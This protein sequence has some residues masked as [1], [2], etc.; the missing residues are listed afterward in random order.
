MNISRPATGVP[1]SATQA[2]TEAILT[3][4]VLPVLFALALPTIAVLFI[5]TF[6]GLTETYFVSSLGSH[7][8]AGV[9]VVFPLLMLMQM[10][11]NGG[12]GSGLAAAVARAIGAGRSQ[13]A[14][15]LVWH[16][17]W[18]AI[19]LGII[20]SAALIFGG[21][22]LYR[23]MGVSG[24][25]L[26]AALAY[27]NIIFLASPLIWL[28]AMLSAAMR[29]AGDT[30]TP[31]RIT[32][33]GAL[34]LLPISPLLIFG[35]GPV[36]AFGVE[37]AGMAI[38]LYYLAAAILLVKRMLRPD[39]ALELVPAPLNAT[40]F[41]EIAGVGMLASVGTVQINLTVAVVTA[42]VGT[43]G[44]A[45]VAGYGIASRLEYIQVP[46]LFGLG[47]AIMTM[48]GVNI[49]AGQ[50]KRAQRIAWI[51]A[52]VAFIFTSLIGLLAAIAPR[53]WLTLFSQD[54]EIL[55]VGSSYMHHVAPFYGCIGAAM[56]L[57]FA[58]I[59]MKRVL[60]PVLAG[61][62]RM[63]VAAF[64]G[65]IAVGY[66]G[67]DIN[68]LFQIYALSAVLYFA[69]TVISIWRGNYVEELHGKDGSKTFAKNRKCSE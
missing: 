5:Q 63:I 68:T 46:L 50:I 36:P 12:F 47:T 54:P 49:G 28:V 41:L 22:R 67:S 55:A 62:V 43:F 40:S 37:G 29:G 18:V 26:E 34:L 69:I 9:S 66:F 59:A 30:A 24:P 21:P 64:I 39:A 20:C 45:A 23:L 2:K 32:L 35:W 56:T 16:G 11:A 1:A 42:A 51:G 31:A 10:M 33:G 52:V 17:V 65:W 58:S 61:T 53:L 19:S 4:P 27:S 3:G 38:I 13:Q 57:Y 6:V 14:A 7:A 60:W 44:Q 15:S 25:A 8:L 48:V